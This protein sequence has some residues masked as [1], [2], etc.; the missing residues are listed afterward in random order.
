MNTY[1]KCYLI[2]PDEKRCFWMSAGV[3]SYQLCDRMY[4]CDDCPTDQAMRRCFAPA[5]GNGAKDNAASARAHFHDL[6]QEGYLYSRNHWWARRIAP[7][8]FR[9]GIEEG[10]AVALQEVRGIVF[11]S[12]QQQLREGQTCVW[13]ILDGGTVPLEAPMG[14]VVRTLNFDLQSKP[15]WIGLHPFQEGWLFEMEAENADAVPADLMAAA[16]AGPKYKGDQNR[17]LTSLTGAIRGKRTQVGLTLADGGEKLRSL[18]AM[19]GSARYIA[20][21]RQHFGAA[22]RQ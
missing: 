16:E 14:G 20:L 5:P 1:R 18:I 22:R 19:L 6:P 8:A 21:I 3:V 11:P 7:A 15:H 4:E 13:V 9:L 12:L 17:F 10:L 2:P